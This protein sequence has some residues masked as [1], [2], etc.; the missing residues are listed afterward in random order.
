M[1]VRPVNGRESW[2]KTYK[3]FSQAL[4]RAGKV[5]TEQGVRIFTK[6]C[7]NWLSDNNAQWPRG[8]GG[9]AFKSGYRGGNHYYPWYTGTLHDSIATVVSDRNRVMAIRYMYDMSRSHAQGNQTYK[10]Q[11]INGYAWAQE[12][13]RRSQ[14]VFLP[15]IQMRLVIGV[16][17][18]NDVDRMPE[19]A[20]YIREFERD[21]GSTMTSIAETRIKNIA[22]KDK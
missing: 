6:A 12:V 20:G 9:G 10:G 17:Y 13:A 11:I 21:F 8:E 7:E 22:F 15:G 18:A 1:A 2:G 14:Y 4:S 19:H 5:F 3:G 16:P